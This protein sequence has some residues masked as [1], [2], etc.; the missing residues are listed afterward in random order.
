M[1]IP[2]DRITESP[3]DLS[4]AESTDELNFIY[5]ADGHRDFR[6]PPFLDVNLVYYRSGRDLFFQGRLGGIIEGCCSRCLKSYSFT[7]G[8]EFSFVL[9]P[10][11]FSAKSKELNRDELG[12]SF[13]AAEEINLT[14][15]IK[16]QVLL[17]LPTRPLCEEGCRGLCMG[18]GAN[19]NEESCPCANSGGDPRMAFF[20]TLKLDQ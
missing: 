6:F 11:P 18:C 13:Y 5:G 16:E 19:L 2:V 3:E 7:L 20:R 4:F 10:E 12:L 17:A 15:F 14:P 9:T 1:K 8:K